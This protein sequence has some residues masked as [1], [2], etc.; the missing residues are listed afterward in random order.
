MKSWP[1]YRYFSHRSQ[2]FLFGSSAATSRGLLQSALKNHQTL[3]TQIKVRSFPYFSNTDL[4]QIAPAS[5]ACAFFP[6]ARQAF[7]GLFSNFAHAI[8]QGKGAVPR[9]VVMRFAYL[10]DFPGFEEFGDR[11]EPSKRSDQPV[12]Y[13]IYN[14]S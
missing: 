13:T 12:I 8:G 4:K 1:T 10:W 9:S 7:T 3:E 5:P 2:H 6:V 11:G 14:Y